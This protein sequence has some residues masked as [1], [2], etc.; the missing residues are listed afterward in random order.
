MTDTSAETPV[1]EEWF[2]GKFLPLLSLTWE[3]S[4]SCYLPAAS[5]LAAGMAMR[6]EIEVCAPCGEDNLS[7][8]VLG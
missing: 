8:S 3:F 7:K 6:G 4:L 1:P 5:I 2:F